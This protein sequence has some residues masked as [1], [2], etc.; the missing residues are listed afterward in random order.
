MK[1]DQIKKFYSE[2]DF[3]S[4]AEIADEIDWYKVKDKAMLNKVADI[5]ENIR[6]YDKAKEILLIAYERSPLGRQLAYKLTILA[7]RTKNYVEADEF[8][9][10][11]VEMAPTDVT[12][13]LLKYRIAKAKGEHIDVLL[14]ILE[15]YVEVEMDERWQYELAKLYHEA[16]RDDDCVKM[17]KELELW[18]NEGKYVNKAK[19]LK[20]LITDGEQDYSDGY[21]YDN[22]QEYQDNS[23]FFLI[24]PLFSCL[25]VLLANDNFGH[26]SHTFQFLFELKLILLNL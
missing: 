11:F 18:F 3:E 6:Q 1:S 8:Y 24:I 20:K 13:Y 22:D 5:Y 2:K 10:D 12:Q 26:T 23:V 9:Q 4:A 15:A 25:P 16:G 19:E 14:R 17:C 7:L 21:S